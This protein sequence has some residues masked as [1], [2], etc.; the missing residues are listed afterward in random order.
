MLALACTC[1]H[2][3]IIRYGK[4][5]SW[6]ECW[7]CAA[8]GRMLGCPRM[9]ACRIHTMPM[10]VYPPSLA[11]KHRVR[12]HMTEPYIQTPLCRCGVPF[13]GS[14]CAWWAQQVQRLAGGTKLGT[15]NQGWGSV[16]VAAAT[17]AHPGMSKNEL[18]LLLFL[19]IRVFA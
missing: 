5:A 11:E 19:F 4:A 15:Q 10:L 18:I 3:S 13:I 1:C 2:R 6:L 7:P 12:V 16:M 9:H 8:V 17:G 14:M